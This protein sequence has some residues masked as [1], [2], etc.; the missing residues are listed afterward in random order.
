MKYQPTG[1]VG[2]IR[3]SELNMSG[4]PTSPKPMISIWF[5]HQSEGYLQR[6]D[7]TRCVLFGD[8]IQ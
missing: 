5:E 7:G 3:P 2:A 1:C 6:F 8:I 4:K